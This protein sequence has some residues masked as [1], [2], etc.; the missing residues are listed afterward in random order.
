MTATWSLLD[1]S[2]M[3]EAGSTALPALQGIPCVDVL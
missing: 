2:G 1:T 3:L